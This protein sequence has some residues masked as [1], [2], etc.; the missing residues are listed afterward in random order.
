MS[1]V[2]L[3][4]E[5]GKYAARDAIHVAV[6]PAV[7][8][9]KLRPGE[10]V[11]VQ[12]G[13]ALPSNQPVGIVDPFLEEPVES[14]M[15]FWLCLMPETVTG[16]RHHWSHPAFKDDNVARKYTK[17]ESEAWLRD[18]AE[19]SDC[20]DFDILIAAATGKS[21]SCVDPDYYG[22]YENDGEYLYFSGRDAH[23]EIPE[24]FWDHVENYTGVKCELR[25]K[26]F[27]CSC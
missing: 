9:A 17:E 5:P 1:N 21:I 16:M 12:D 15:R 2:Y 18:F 14:G 4:E 23:G 7:A 22:T 6:I 19:T 11:S 27:S 8:G 24:E 25:A 10:R 13:V 26:R 20:P 3:G